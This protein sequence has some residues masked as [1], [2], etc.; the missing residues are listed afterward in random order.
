MGF[1]SSTGETALGDVVEKHS[2]DQILFHKQ[3]NYGDFLYVY[4]IGT[5]RILA[6]VLGVDFFGKKI[7]VEWVVGSTI[8][9]KSIDFSGYSLDESYGDNWLEKAK[10]LK[11]GLI[12]DLRYFRAR[13]FD[14]DKIDPDYFP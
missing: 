13:P 14:P 2:P 8:L 6:R 3:I 5:P 7:T 1:I 9:I 12:W 11:T 10:G 4:E